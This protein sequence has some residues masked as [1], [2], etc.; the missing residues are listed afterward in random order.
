MRATCDTNI[1]ARAAVRPAGPA[2]AVLTELVS[3]QHVLVL[4][5]HIVS[6]LARVL[7]YERVR[8]QA[9]LTDAEIDSFVNTMYANWPNL[10]PCP[11]QCQGRQ[12]TPMTTLLSRPPWTAAPRSS[13]RATGISGIRCRRLIAPLSGF[14]CSPMS[15]CCKN[16]DACSRMN[17][18]RS[19]RQ[20]PVGR[21]R[22][23]THWIMHF[24]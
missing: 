12:A 3:E 15:S 18:A 13:A 16:S 7:R 9:E 20:I 19:D 11:I 17:D 23:S 14:V 4:S 2:R 8:I 24:C 10:W 1:L 5:E 6:E 22:L 21:L